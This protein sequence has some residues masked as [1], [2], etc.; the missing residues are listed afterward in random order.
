MILNLGPRAT[1]KDQLLPNY[2]SRITRKKIDFLAQRIREP[3]PKYSCVE[4][5]SGSHSAVT[6]HVHFS[7][8]K[9]ARKKCKCFLNFASQVQLQST[10][11]KWVW[12]MTTLD[13]KTIELC[14]PL[15]FV[16]ILALLS[17]LSALD[18]CMA[19]YHKLGFGEFC[20]T[21]MCLVTTLSFNTFSILKINITH[22]GNTELWNT[23][24]LVIFHTKK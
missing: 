1:C 2:R 14:N 17:T 5:I 23:S 24:I 15:I 20:N 10:I 7:R 4:K 9:N 11:L 13:W 16:V 18:I 3:L 8:T 6:V 22:L 19:F 21:N 12:R